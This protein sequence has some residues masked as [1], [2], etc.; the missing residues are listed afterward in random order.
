[1]IFAWIKAWVGDESCDWPVSVMCEVLN[2]GRSGYY[3]WRDRKPGPRREQRMK[4]QQQVKD[5]HEVAGRF[6][7]GSPRV[8]AELKA[9]GVSICENTVAKL[10]REQGLTVKPKRRFVPQTTDSSHDCPIA[11]NRLGRDF[12]AAAPNT[13]WTGDITYIATDEGWLYLAVVL[14]LYSRRIVGWSMRPHLRAELACEALEMALRSR[15][16]RTG[17]LLYHSDRGVQY[18]SEAYRRLLRDAG[19]EASMS[20]PGNCYDNAVTESFFSTLKTELVNHERYATHDEAR[21]SLFEWIEVFYNR[22]RRHSSLEYFE[23]RS[24]R[25]QTQLTQRPR[26]VGKVTTRGK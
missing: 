17:E 12:T 8:T 11:P 6:T 26:N 10:M 21:R 23:P 7:Y 4:W 20:R 18:A 22:Q 19:A 16:P 13:R 2:V 24:V 15:R 1:V 9:Q 3:A 25:G 5:A 14:D